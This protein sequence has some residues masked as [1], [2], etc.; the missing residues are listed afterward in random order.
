MTR[1]PILERAA[2]EGRTN[3][4]A[5]LSEGEVL[6]GT[7]VRLTDH[8]AFIDL[9]GVDGLLHASKIRQRLKTQKEGEA[10]RV[11]QRI[12]VEVVHVDRERRRVGLDFK[13]LDPDA[14]G[15]AVDDYKVGDEVTGWVSKSDPEGIIVSLEEGVQGFIPRESLLHLEVEPLTGAI[16]K[17]VV[18]A[19]DAVK[20]QITLRP[21]LTSR[22]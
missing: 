8:G 22:N 17:A 2:E 5:R 19:V 1:R 3:A 14:F 12:T 15:R 9:G 7:V 10:L 20:R 21:S 11:G 4:L 18:T 13:R 16:V 6:S